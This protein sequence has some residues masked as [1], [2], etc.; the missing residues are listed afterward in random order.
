MPE[1]LSSS[2][3]E[4][5]NAISL[6]DPTVGPEA[7]A[8][9]DEL[10]LSQ[11]LWARLVAFV[12]GYFSDLTPVRLAS[13][14]AII[15][16]AALVL[17]LSHV[18]MPRWELARPEPPQ[19][20]AAPDEPL[21]LISFWPNRGG[22][23]LESSDSLMRAA[24]PFTII[25]DR[26]REGII[27]YT[28]KA[29]DTLTSI[30]HRYGLKVETVMWASGL[31]LC[32]QLLKVGQQLIILPV[33]GVYH[34]VEE[35]DTIA[36]IARQY[37]V[38][39]EAIVD[40]EPNGLEDEN[41]P[42]TPGQV[43]I[44]PGGEKETISPWVSALPSQET[45]PSEKGTGHFAWPARGKLVDF[46]GTTTIGGKPGGKPRRW[47]HKGIDIA[48]PLGTPVLAADSGRVTVARGGYNGGYGNYVVINHGNGF[49]TLYAHL[50]VISV[51]EGAIV[52]KGQRIGAVGATGNTTGT[53][54]HFEIRYRNVPRNPLCFLSAP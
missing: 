51:Q 14:A 7:P 17:I 52:A 13:H 44:I 38:Q 28:V 4:D 3:S 33:D 22:S 34:T 30:A 54:L 11:D 39:P 1:T 42:L 41:A 12:R 6:A 49:S 24:V 23:R 37:K 9:D 50:S 10:G 40:Y 5:D 36:S 46:F 45:K 32:P 27:T 15:L 2:Y 26:P 8:D 21:P 18:E 43:L 16:V 29:G 53:H 35:G 48:A 20:P 25:P 19:P 47:P 31:E